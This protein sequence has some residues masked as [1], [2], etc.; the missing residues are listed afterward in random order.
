MTILE[1][2]I[3]GAINRSKNL[4]EAHVAAER[5]AHD[6]G[7]NRRVNE[8]ALGLTL[9]ETK[10]LEFSRALATQPAL[11]L[12]DEPMAGLNSEEADHLGEMIKGIAAS[13]VTIVVIEHNVHSL[14]RIVDYMIGLDDGKRVAEGLP[15]EVVNNPQIIKAY[16]GSRWKEEHHAGS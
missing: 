6:M 5:I 11:L 13:G 4:G 3:T 9:W 2:I 14:L 10:V 16:L 12:I 1:N 7:L 8:P 15:Q